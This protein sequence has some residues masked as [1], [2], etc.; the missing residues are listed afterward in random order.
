MSASVRIAAMMLAL[1]MTGARAPA[2]QAA[3]SPAARVRS[4]AETGRL[5]EAERLARDG[6]PALLLPLGEVLA[7]QGRLAAAESAFAAV[8]R[9]AG[10]DQRTAQA[11]LAEL[12]ARRGDATTAHRLADGLAASYERDGDRWPPMDRVAAGRAYVV[13]APGD[14]EAARAALRA[15]DSAIAVDSGL[16][17]P[18]LRTGDLFLDHYNAPD[19]EASYQEVLKLA[20]ENARALLGMARVEQFQGKP[21]AFQ[22]V[23]RSLKINPALVPALVLQGELFLDAEAHDSAAAAGRRALAVDSS[24][25]GGWALLGAVALLGGDSARFAGA[26]AEARRFHPRPAAFYATIAEWTA[27]HR[28]YAGAVRLGREAVASDSAS[29]EALGVLGMNELR[30]GAMDSGRVHLERAFAHDPFHVWYKNTL[31]LLDALARYRTITTGRFQIVAPAAQADLLALYLAPLLEEAYDTFAARYEY[32]PPT[33]V[34]I[35]LY[36]RHPDF[37]VRTA[38]LT[39]LGALGVSFGTVLAMDA[40]SARAAGDFNWGSTAWHELAHT[41]TLGLSAHKVPRWFSEGLSVLEERRARTGWGAGPSLAFLAA[42]KGDRL[43]AM[44]RLNEGFVRPRHP[45]EIQFSYYQASLVCQLI[46]EQWGRKALVGMLRAYRD[47]LDTPGVFQRVLGVTEDELGRRFVTWTRERFAPALAG[48][49]PWDGRSAPEGQFVTLLRAAEAS[50][51]A[52]KPEEARPKLERAVAM[53][54]EYT[55][56]DA[57]LV[58]LAGIRAE[59]GDRKGAADLLERYNAVDESSW[60]ANQREAKLREELQDWPGEQKVLER[61]IWI[62]PGE[63]SLHERLATVAERLGDHRTALRERRAVLAAGPAD[64]SEARYQLA[65]ALLA[66]G[67]PAGAR[68]EVLQVLENA[69]GFEKAQAL[70]LEL[71]NRRPEG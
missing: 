1:G 71:A 60:E 27:R 7:L 65:R 23:Q 18:R 42:F 51:Q 66:A 34:R 61:M 31:D 70:L 39:G 58:L 35:E 49:D 30:V 12:A 44:N 29:P 15:F 67:D 2:G 40:P 54:P 26:A 25:L 59:Q 56:E 47:G 53:F 24:A 14:A 20:P 4:L 45:A 38:G 68:R 43:L 46:E 33:P 19:A 36:G 16:I 50:L 69:P 17:E 37:S 48:V 6:G 11:A 9:G 10:P 41:F 63:A 3:Q 21:G 55:G 64:V 8:A 52:G 28:Q 5:A 13:L 62:S 32:R 57:P 22:T